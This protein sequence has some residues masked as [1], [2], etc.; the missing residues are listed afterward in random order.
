[1]SEA[2]TANGTLTKKTQRQLRWTVSQPPIERPRDARQ[3]P[4][5]AE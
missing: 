5:R 3:S 1:M 2:T 4:D